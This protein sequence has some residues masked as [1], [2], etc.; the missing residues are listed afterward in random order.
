MK[1]SIDKAKRRLPV[2]MFSAVEILAL[3]IECT[4]AVTMQECSA[5]C[6]AAKVA[7]ALNGMNRNEFLKS[8]YS[9]EALASP[10]EVLSPRT[11][12]DAPTSRSQ[13]VP[14]ETTAKPGRATTAPANAVFPSAIS[15]KYWSDSLDKRQMHTCLDQYKLNQV[16]KANGRLGS[17]MKGGGYYSQCNKT[18]KALIFGG[19]Q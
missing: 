11:A 7:S 3:P 19:S 13:P 10:T 6:K 5:R 15:S 14:T 1:S 2:T 18:T 16:T 8:Q 17:I 4:H 9:S 12:Q